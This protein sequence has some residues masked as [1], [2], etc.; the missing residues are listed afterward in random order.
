MKN[1]SFRVGLIYSLSL[2]QNATSPYP[3]LHQG[4]LPAPGV[5]VLRPSDLYPGLTTSEKNTSVSCYNS[6]TITVSTSGFV[7]FLAQRAPLSGMSLTAHLWEKKKILPKTPKDVS[8]T[9]LRLCLTS[10][11]S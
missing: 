8:A 10:C 2:S 11:S 6:I 3:F 4:K 1:T 7:R 9:L 5:R